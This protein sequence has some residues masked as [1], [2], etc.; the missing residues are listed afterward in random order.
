MSY[1]APPRGWGNRDI[2]RD[3]STD[4]GKEDNDEGEIGHEEGMKE[5]PLE[6]RW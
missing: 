1:F 6:K 2:D 3:G 5:G 4:R